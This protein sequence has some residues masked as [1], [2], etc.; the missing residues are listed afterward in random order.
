MGLNL[1]D[2]NYAGEA[3]SAFIVKAI[4]EGVTIDQGHCYVQ[5]GIKKKF[6]IPRFALDEDIIQD[7]ATTP[8]SV[9]DA[10]I[11]GQVLEPQNYLIYFEFNPRQFENHWLAV[12]MNPELLDATLPATAEA[13]VIQEVMKINAKFI[14]K[15]IW[16]GQK[17]LAATSKLKYIDGWLKKAMLSSDTIDVSS[18]TT[19]SAANIVA[20]FQKGY[21]LIPEALRYDDDMKIFVSFKTFDLY[22]TA[23]KNQ[24]NKGVDFTQRGKDTFN[25]LKVVRVP[26]FP[27][28]MYYIAKGRPDMT[29]NLWVGMNSVDDETYVQIAK[30]QANSDAWFVKAEMKIDAQV[31]WFQETVLYG[32]L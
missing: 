23:Q 12:Q 1:Q 14:N 32:S 8:T 2:T 24:A 11:D 17:S 18:P 3:A 20:E 30:K 26:D 7:Y 6:T 22:D 29:S 4:T 19:L 16:I 13:T 27:N 10:T 28:D 21:D 25:G 15:L 9:A 31:G 5:D